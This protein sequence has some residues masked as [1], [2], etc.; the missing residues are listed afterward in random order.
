LESGG[1]EE[2]VHGADTVAQ[3]V[4]DVVATDVAGGPAAP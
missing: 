4:T 3:D 1:E 2:P